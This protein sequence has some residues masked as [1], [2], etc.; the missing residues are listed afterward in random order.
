MKNDRANQGTFSQQRP[1]G[2][3][4]GHIH[5]L[6]PHELDHIGDKLEQVEISAVLGQHSDVEIPRFR[7]TPA[8]TAEDREQVDVPPQTKRAQLTGPGRSPQSL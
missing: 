1:S 5:L 3:E 4:V 8:G 2:V 7:L 6:K